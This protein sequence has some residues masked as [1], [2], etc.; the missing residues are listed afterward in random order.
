MTSDSQFLLSPFPWLAKMRREAPVFYD[1]KQQAWMV[2]RYE[3]V[4]QGCFT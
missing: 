1:T 3:D 4:A 2:F